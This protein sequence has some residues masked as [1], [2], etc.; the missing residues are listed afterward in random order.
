MFAEDVTKEVVVQDDGD[1]DRE[2]HK[3]LPQG[4]SEKI[5]QQTG[6]PYYEW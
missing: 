1:R 5:D 6:R 2:K 3:P 4:W